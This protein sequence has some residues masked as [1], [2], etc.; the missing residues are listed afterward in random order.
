MSHA[1]RSLFDKP[2][3][4]V[5]G[6]CSG[7]SMD[8]V[9][10]AACQ[11]SGDGQSG[12]HAD[13][14]AYGTEPYSKD[15][16]KIL[17]ELSEQKSVST[18]D[19]SKLNF[20]L[21]RT[22]ARAATKIIEK[23]G[24][25]PADIDLIGCHGQTIAHLPPRLDRAA[26]T[27]SMEIQRV[28][29]TFEIGE[30][31]VLAET[32]GITVVSNFRA[33]DI[34]AGGQGWPLTPFVD[35]S[36]FSSPDQTRAMVNI[37]G[38]TSITVLPAGGKADDVVAFDSGP[39]CLLVDCMMQV[40]TL[41]KQ[42]YDKNGELAATGKANEYLMQELLKHAYIQ[43]SPPKSTGREEFG[44][45]FSERLYEHGIRRG[46]KPTDVLR[47]ATEFT[48]ITIADAFKRFVTPHW[49]LE[50]AVLSGGGSLNPLLVNRLRQ[51]LGS[52]VKVVT[53]DEYGLPSRSK[54]AVCIAILAREAI[55]GRAGNLPRAS[56]AVHARVLG[57]ITQA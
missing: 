28:G 51:E 10:M 54:E 37:G 2:V 26:G 36:L 20:R 3:M 45:K 11:I 43:R 23:A 7:A 32:M 9:D 44:M 42:S 24:L 31:A 35:Y 40:M 57:Q 18:D 4:K 39:G 46:I 38:V 14:L 47:T 16:S 33:R 53:T 5:V 55:M 34:A 30:P 52:S 48:A 13:L 27:S 15:M 29:S 19:I 49:K 22:Y 17:A 8:G 1:L 50:E 56:G 6:L 41:G 25:K 21:G 12:L